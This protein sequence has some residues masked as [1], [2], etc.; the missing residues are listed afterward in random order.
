MKHERYLMPAAFFVGFIFDNFTLTRID[1][2]LD[3]IILFT[4]LILAGIGITVVNLYNSNRLRSR[5]IEPVARMSPLMVQFA[6]GGLFSG[7]IIF[8]TR[9]ASLATSWLFILMLVLLV[10]GNEYFQKRY[11]HFSFQVS[12]FFIALFSFTIFYIPILLG[13]MGAFVFILSGFISIAL[14][15]FFIYLLSL[16]MPERVRKS[17]KVLILSIGGI[18]LALN[19]LYFTNIIPPIPLSLKSLDVYHFVDRTPL[20]NYSVLYERKEWYERFQKDYHFYSMAGEPVYIYSSVFA[21]TD[22]N[23][24]I[25]HRWQYFDLA[26]NEWTTTD[27]LKFS[28]SGGRDGGYR[29]YSSKENITPGRWRTE[30]ITERGQLLGRITFTVTNT[31]IPPILERNEL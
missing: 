31:L 6:F 22:L 25:L 23:T 10:V 3:N 18:Y 9:S 28:I 30:V 19:I 1:L 20:G 5:F 4:Y 26:K 21:P 8:Y 13:T 11:Q 12:I 7:Y 27:L 15:L 14:I 2:L 24:N 29:G 17:K 16:A